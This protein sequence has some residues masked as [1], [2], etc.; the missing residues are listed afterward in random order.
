MELLFGALVI[1]LVGLVVALRF[2]A[3]GTRALRRKVERFAAARRF[4]LNGDRTGFEAVLDGVRLKARMVVTPSHGGR[5]MTWIVEGQAPQVGA[6]VLS[7][8][9][10]HED[11]PVGLRTGHF[12]CDERFLV[13]GTSLRVAIQLLN[14]EARRALIAF[15]PRG[16]SFYENGA[17]RFEWE[18][19]EPA[20]FEDIDRAVAIVVAI[21]R[22]PRGYREESS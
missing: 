22:T 11:A 18:A 12:D 3:V 6:G 7:L 10:K 15:G 2:G 5:T 19:P 17:F 13:E 8:R 21:C 20:P 16:E 14:D 9:P 1:G 4:V